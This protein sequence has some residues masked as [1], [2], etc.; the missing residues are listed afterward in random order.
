MYLL[1]DRV[2]LPTPLQWGY[3]ILESGPTIKLPA[4]GA[5][6]RIDA[7][8]LEFVLTRHSSLL[9]LVDPCP[10]QSV[11]SIEKIPTPVQNQVAASI[12][13]LE[14]SIERNRRVDEKLIPWLAA[15]MPVLVSSV[16]LFGGFAHE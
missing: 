16:S 15:G 9:A 5:K 10:E 1:P 8:K 11:Y 6:A 13:R 3:T 12:A 4:P 14:G 7:W 2:P